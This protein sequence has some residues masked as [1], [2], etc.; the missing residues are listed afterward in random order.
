MLNAVEKVGENKDKLFNFRPAFFAAICLIFGILFGYYNIV[1]DVSAWWLLCAIPILATPLFFHAG[2]RDMFVRGVTVLLLASTFFLGFSCFR[3]QL[4]DYTRCGYYNGEYTVTGTVVSYVE[5][6]SSVTVVL[7]DVNVDGNE[8]EGRLKA[9]LP[10]SYAGETRIADVVVIEGRVRTDT[11]YLK[12]YF[13]AS[14][15]NAKA[16]YPMDNVTACQKVGRS[17]D[18]FLCIRDRVEKVIVSGMDKT[19][20]AITLGV[21]TGDD[22]KIDGGLLYNMRMGGV[23]H[24]FAVSGLHVGALYGFVVLLFTKTRLRKTNPVSQFIVLAFV[25]LF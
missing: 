14:A 18:V 10:S 8:E 24:I 22:T 13:K 19:S 5:N 2:K 23:A 9:Y 20:A 11:T 1:Y 4:Y 16:T 7:K 6:G 12:D 15:V 21:L 25:L 3:Y 17:K